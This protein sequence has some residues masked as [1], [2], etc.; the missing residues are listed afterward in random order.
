MHAAL[1]GVPYSGK[2]TMF[3]ALS[4]IEPGAKEELVG[5][6]KV[7]DARVDCLRS[8][9]N[10]ARTKYAEFVLHD[11][12]AGGGRNETIPARVKNL[13]ERMEML[14]FVVRDFESAFSGD[15]RDPA[16]EYARL[17]E[18]IIL[19]D[20]M[21]VEKRLE[22]EAKERRNPPEIP[23]LKK[24]RA[25]LE[26]NEIPA[27]EELTGQELGQVSSYNLLTLKKRVAIVNKPEGETGIPP[28]LS[29]MLAREKVPGFDV[30]GSLERELNDIAPAER[31][32]FLES[33]GLRGTARDRLLAAAYETSGL[34]SFLTVG[35]D[36]VRAWPI[37][38]G[39]TAVEAAGKIHKDIARGFIRAETVPFDVFKKHG[40]EEACKEA[41]AYR[42]V[43]KDYVVRDGDIMEF[44]F[45][46]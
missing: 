12:G 9:F 35:P 11:F 41:N 25:R 13:I 14:V 15:P 4:G 31:R 2:T 43:G 29:E 8:V 21:T 26:A 7:P 38:S 37:R 34:I 3:A 23:V 30:S 40:S 5:V 27:V 32:A 46:V 22:R 18:E 19:A 24:I 17:R 16:A 33:Y 42:L 28:A 10:P 44:R 20:F 36:E 1:V 45:N 39:M 6:I